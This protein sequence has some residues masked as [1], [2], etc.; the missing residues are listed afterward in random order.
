MQIEFLIIGQGLCGTW[1]S[2]YL[3]KENRSFLV[4]DN[5]KPDSASRTAAGIINPV[6][7]RRLVTVWMDDEILPFAW[8]AYNEMSMELPLSLSKGPVISQNSIIE[9]SLPFNYRKFFWKE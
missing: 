5:N 4:I 7:G 6:T 2:Y 9:F 1:V 8:H 3:Q